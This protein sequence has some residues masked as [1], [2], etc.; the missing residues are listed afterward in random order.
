MVSDF[1][2]GSIQ[3]LSSSRIRQDQL[4]LIDRGEARGAAE[5]AADLVIPKYYRVSVTIGPYLPT[6]SFEKNA[7][8]IEV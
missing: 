3:Y 1:V 2:T 8:A 4:I 6:R 5:D 7:S